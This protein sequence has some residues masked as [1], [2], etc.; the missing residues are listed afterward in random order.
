M[1]EAWAWAA[2]MTSGEKP[3][4]GIDFMRASICAGLM[5]F[6]C[7]IANRIISGFMP[8]MVRG[9]G[10]VSLSKKGCKEAAFEG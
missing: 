4:A 7:S 2:R 3:P 10:R 6:I 1:R 5:F 8:S 9:R